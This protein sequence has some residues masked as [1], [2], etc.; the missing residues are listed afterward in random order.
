MFCFCIPMYCVYWWIVICNLVSLEPNAI[1]IHHRSIRKIA[2]DRPR[3]AIPK[4]AAIID[5][6]EPW[7]GRWQY[8][9]IPDSSDAVASGEEIHHVSIQTHG[10]HTP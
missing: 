5:R 7:D 6:K 10:T 3:D 9:S 4:T 1:H 2:V 8:C